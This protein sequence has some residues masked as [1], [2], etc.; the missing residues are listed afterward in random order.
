MVILFL[1]G[2]FNFI[3]SPASSAKAGLYSFP[4]VSSVCSISA[5]CCTLQRISSTFLHKPVHHQGGLHCCSMG[6]GEPEE[7]D[8]A[9]P[10][11][12]CA[13][14]PHQHIREDGETHHL[15]WE[16][17]GGRPQLRHRQWAPQPAPSPLSLVPAVPQFPFRHLPDMGIACNH[18]GTKAP[19]NLVVAWS[20]RP[21]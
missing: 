2:E 5:A 7:L 16:A 3:V 6:C 14:L 12:T 11:G 15:T 20:W 10:M 4:G 13:A 1:Q 17:H 8:P 9:P 18:T 21:L 19:L